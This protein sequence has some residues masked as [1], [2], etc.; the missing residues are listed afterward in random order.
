MELIGKI[1]RGRRDGVIRVINKI[2]R[3]ACKYKLI[4]LTSIEVNGNL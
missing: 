1:S 3:A 2:Y 4:V